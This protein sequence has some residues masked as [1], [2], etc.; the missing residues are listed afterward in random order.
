MDIETALREYLT[1]FGDNQRISTWVNN[2]KRMVLTLTAPNGAQLEFVA[3]G[4]QL[5]PYRPPSHAQ[6]VSAVGFDAHGPM[7]ERA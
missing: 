2:E 7:G 3:V 5:V 1:S 4:D 6:R